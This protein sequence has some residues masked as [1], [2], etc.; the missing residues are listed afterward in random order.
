MFV[1]CVGVGVGVWCLPLRAVR[2][3]GGALTNYLDRAKGSDNSDRESRLGLVS[4]GGERL[5]LVV[6]S[7]QST[8]EV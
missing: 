6:C 4:D 7:S 8:A 2:R 3:S 5:F 1:V